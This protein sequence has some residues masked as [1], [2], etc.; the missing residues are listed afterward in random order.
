MKKK[1]RIV[2]FDWIILTDQQGSV[3]IQ[4]ITTYLCEFHRARQSLMV[5]LTGWMGP[6]PIHSASDHSINLHWLPKNKRF[7]GRNDGHFDIAYK[8]G[9]TRSPV[10]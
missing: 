5:V 3:A 6:E 8:Q 7:D 2:N 9:F 10:R 4:N 1:K